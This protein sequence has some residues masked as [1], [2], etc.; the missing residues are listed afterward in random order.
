MN[1]VYGRLLLGEMELDRYWYTIHGIN[2]KP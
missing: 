2:Y 1:N